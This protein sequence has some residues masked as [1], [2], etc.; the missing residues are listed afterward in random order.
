[1]LRVLTYPPESRKDGYWIEVFSLFWTAASDPDRSF[2]DS[3]V[4]RRLT[5]WQPP[6]ANVPHDLEPVT[7]W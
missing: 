1:M 6:F 3:R 7:D 5:E 4:K 2:A